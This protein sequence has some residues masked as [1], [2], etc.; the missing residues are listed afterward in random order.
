ML[1]SRGRRLVTVVGPDG[2]EP[3]QPVTPTSSRPASLSG[4]GRR[5]LSITA[6]PPWVRTHVPRMPSSVVGPGATCSC[7]CWPACRRARP[8]GRLRPCR[9]S[10]AEAGRPPWRR[11]S[12][13]TS[14]PHLR[15]AQRSVRPE[16]TPGGRRRRRAAP[17][18]A[19]GLGRAVPV[20]A[21]R[22]P[23]GTGPPPRPRCGGRVR[24]GTT[25]PVRPGEPARRCPPERQPA[26]LT[27][28]QPVRRSALHDPARRTGA[29][30]CPLHWRRGR[31]AP[32]VR[33]FGWMLHP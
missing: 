11:A 10:P 5:S 14:A 27:S 22:V 20:A 12:R 33:P 17:A 2:R 4:T 15:A 6:T 25:R 1:G 29:H 31:W 21:I 23:P 8:P 9:R 13:T 30:G 3:C 26:A 24:C 19:T 32:R 28:A 7:R 16:P 18:R